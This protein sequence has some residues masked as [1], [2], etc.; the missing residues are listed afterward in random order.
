MEFV[1]EHD[2]VILGAGQAGASAAIRLAQMGLDVGLLERLQFPRGHV[3]ICISDETVALIDYLGLGRE[4]DDAQFW[5]RHLTAVRWGDPEARL[6][7]QQGYHVDRAVLDELMLRRARSVGARIYQPAQLQEVRRLE[8][9]GWSVTIAANERRQRLKAQFIVDAAGRRPAISGARI[10]DGPPLV[11][12]H[13]NWAPSRTIAFDGLIEAGEDAWL[14]YAQTGHNQAVVS[15][16]CDPR[17]LRAG[18]ADGMQAQYAGVLRQFRALRPQ[19]LGEQSSVPQV[20]DATSHHAEDPVGDGYIRLGDACFSVDPL[21]SQGV[22]LALQSG[23]QGSIVVNTILRKPENTEAAQQ[24]FLMRTGERIGRYTG[25]TKQEYARVAAIYPNAFWRAR[26]GDASVPMAGDLDSIV[27]SPPRAASDRVAVSPDVSLGA[28][29]VIDGVFVQV[30]Q[31]VR[32]PNINGDVAYVEGVDLARLLSALPQ[33]FA[34]CDIPKFWRDH[35]PSATGDR[36]ASW[37][38]SKNVLVRA[39]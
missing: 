6:V 32:H 29:P 27:E 35:V 33:R 18:K 7:P 30:R 34:Y 19:Q 1:A 14:W 31:V 24:F 23:L 38:W 39:V 26:A 2:V 12:I 11:S 13:A 5:R 28:A 15:V 21:S 9:F 10:K 20:C 37:L 17:S 36:I 8:D 16:F 3:G 4:F 22:H 25:R